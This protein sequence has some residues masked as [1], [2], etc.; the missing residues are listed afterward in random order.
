MTIIG[1]IG[2]T[3]MSVNGKEGP[4]SV[5]PRRSADWRHLARAE[6]Y[7]LMLTALVMILVVAAAWIGGSRLETATRNQVADKMDTILN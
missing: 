6:R 3:T 1:R 7:P 5:Q 4:E 2:G